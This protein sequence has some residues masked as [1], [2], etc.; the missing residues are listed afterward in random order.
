MISKSKLEY[1]NSI[2]KIAKGEIKGDILLKN[3]N[4]VNVFSGEIYQTNVVL[5]KTVI[6]GISE[7]YQEANRIFD[8]KGKYLIPGLID[9]HIHIES[10]LLCL[11]EFAKLVLPRG[12]TSIVADPHEITN[13]LGKN[14]IEYMLAAGEEL[15][16][17]VYFMVPSCVPSTHMETAGGE[18]SSADIEFLLQK[19]RIL[20]LAEMMN[21]PGVI[22]GVPEVLKKIQVS[23]ACNR[24]IDGHSPGLSG[25]ELQAYLAVGIESDHECTTKEEA[26]EKLR[27]GMRI[28]IREGSAAKNLKALLPIVNDQTYQRCFFVCDDKHPE[29]LAN[30]G[31]IDHILREAVRLGLN[32]VRAIQ[33]ATINT[34]SYFGLKRKGAIAPGYLADLVVVENLSDFEIKMVFKSGKLVVDQGEL[35]IELTQYIDRSVLDTVHIKPISE[36][37]LKIM[38]KGKKVKVIEIIPNQIITKKLIVTPTVRNGVLVSDIKRDILKM[39]VIERHKMS[40]DIGLGLVKGFG[41]QNGALAS[42]VAHDSHNILVVGTDDQSMILAVQEITK[43]GGGFVVV[44]QGEVKAFLSLPIAGLMSNESAEIVIEKLKKLLEAA[45]KLGSKIDNPFITLS[46]L[47]LPVIPSLK[48][49]DEG[50]VDVDEFKIVP[51]YE[52]FSNDLK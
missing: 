48:L 20:G 34:A 10:S 31:H 7:E 6:A 8:L 33:M 9:G 13:V 41:L 12:T 49:T 4:L 19:D 40:G 39:A 1:L 32:P 50:L 30:Q 46:F 37:N 24:I 43:M 27:S 21:F 36:E 29:D 35:V 38:D 25:K 14:G 2:I 23:K 28:M 42:S 45:R 51:L 15:P 5:F 52:E 11:S 26:I 18:I 3:V 47:A 17:D 22:F 16:L 44:S